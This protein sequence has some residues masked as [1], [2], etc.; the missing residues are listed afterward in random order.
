MKPDRRNLFSPPSLH[1]PLT[2]FWSTRIGFVIQFARI[3]QDYGHGWQAGRNIEPQG[4]E[5]SAVAVHPVSGRR[6]IIWQSG[7]I[8]WL[9]NPDPDVHEIA[10]QVIDH[11][12]AR[13][14]A[15]EETSP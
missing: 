11:E 8:E 9:G 2:E 4:R 7:L 12:I 14:G 10:N 15:F 3:M 1:E 6:V 5:S 13:A